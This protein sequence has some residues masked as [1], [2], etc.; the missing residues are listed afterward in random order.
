MKF[1]IFVCGEG[2]GHTGRCISL[3][4]ELQ[5]SGHSICIGA[6]G[7]SKELIEKSGHA[8]SDIPRELK[9]SGKNGSLDLK[10]SILQT[11]KGISPGKMK[12]VFDLV[13]SIQPDFVISDGYYLGILASIKNKNP[14]CII[15]N[16]SRMQD[17]FANKG[18]VV[19]IVGSMVRKFYTWIYNNVNII[20]IPDF[21][22][23]FTICGSNLAF[24]E[25]F[26]D[27]IEFSGPVLRKRPDEVIPKDDIKRPHVLCSIGGFGYRLQI[28]KTIIEAAKMDGDIHYTLIGGPDLDY[29]LLEEV[30]ENVDIRK[31]VSDPFPYYRS[32]DMVICTG[33][34]GTITE[35]LSF[36]LP[37]ISFPDRLHNEQQNNASFVENNRYGRKFTYSV[38]PE[39]LMQAV[40]SL[41]NDETFRSNVSVLK[42]KAQR[43][44][45]PAYIRKRLESYSGSKSLE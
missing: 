40:H 42:K 8:V 24:P 34:H 45:G 30:P 38:T 39:E 17:F 25:R 15:V 10:S 44:H 23:P 21:P 19:E 4:N 20:F 12:N 31:L 29:N 14:T 43:M 37:V 18:F 6:Y 22:P 33:G 16:Q 35:A 1:L 9:L 13:K 5:S 11:A 2:L 41:I 26:N 36:G 32:V 28:F 27:K 7:Y 3:A